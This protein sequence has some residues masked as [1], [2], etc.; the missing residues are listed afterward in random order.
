[1][2]FFFQSDE[3]YEIAQ[4]NLPDVESQLV[5]KAENLETIKS[6]L[7]EIKEEIK[8]NSDKVGPCS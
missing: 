6:R 7:T 1:M 3:E 4:Q 5:E 8:S 2:V